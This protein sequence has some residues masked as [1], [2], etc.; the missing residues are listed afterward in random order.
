M[1][2]DNFFAEV[3][4][5]QAILYNEPFCCL[6][7]SRSST[8]GG[9]GGRHDFFV[10]MQKIDPLSQLHV[11][12]FSS[13]SNETMMPSGDELRSISWRSLE[14]SHKRIKI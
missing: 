4:F 9:G 5:A 7:V 1:Y 13:N 8:G 3:I 6:S 12:E 14:M 10:F 11:R 2:I